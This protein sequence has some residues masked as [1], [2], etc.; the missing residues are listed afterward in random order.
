M[1]QSC[2]DGHLQK[3]YHVD[4]GTGTIFQLGEQRLNDFSVGEAIIGEKQPRQSNSKYN[5]MQYVFF[6][7]VYAAYNGV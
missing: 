5:F 3:V 1:H 7:K 4:I 6:E 2:D